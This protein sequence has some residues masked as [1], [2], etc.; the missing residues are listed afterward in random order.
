MDIPILL[1]PLLTPLFSAVL[2]LFFWNYHQVQ[3]WVCFVGTSITL[4]MAGLLLREVWNGGMLTLQAGSWPAPFGISLVVDMLSASMVVMVALSG[5]VIF[6]YSLAS[7]DPR[8]VQFGFYPVLLFLMFGLC[9]ALLAGDVFN[10]Y[11]WFEIMLVSCFVLL[12]LGGTRDQ[13][14][15]SVKYV[16]INFISSAIF[17][18]GIGIIYG[19][20]GALNM[21]D[22]A[23]KLREVPDPGL[24]TMAA[25][26]FL[27]SF[28]LKSAIFPLFFW[29]P[30]VYHT[31][32]IPITAMVAG[33]LSKVGVYAMIRFFTLIF[34][35]D[36]GYT[37][38]LL[39]WAAGFSM[40]IGAFGAMVQQDARKVL[41]FSIVSQIGYLMMGIAFFTPLA[42]A[43]VV[44]FLLHSILVKTNL[45]LVTGIVRFTNGSYLL[46]KMGGAYDRYPFIALLFAISA[47]SLTGVP[48]LSGFWG[49]FLLIRAGLEIGEYVLVAVALVASMFTLIY[50][51]KIWMEAFWKNDPR[52]ADEPIVSDSGKPVMV[53]SQS[54]LLVEKVFL[55]LPVV[56]LTLLIL[57]LG[58]YAEPI[59]A[60]AMRASEQLMNPDEYIRTV[61][62]N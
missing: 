27:V 51:T 45:F 38:T 7:L 30:P 3:K 42:L 50:M 2:C 25:V 8:R 4:F 26:F 41:S 31:P 17:L 36:P 47:F 61:L 37:H 33:L 13:L 35:H 1:F 57:G 46:K 6:V 56:L 48:P 19:L 10:L 53:L 9:G 14:E 60:F 12:T 44:Y 34:I 20:T 23:L 22:V 11:V 58:L 54:E 15:G 39:L 21:A 18:S 28:G 40:V 24:A 43:G 55:V 59:L 29:L 62:G 52:E 32:P 16:V 5:W 49:K